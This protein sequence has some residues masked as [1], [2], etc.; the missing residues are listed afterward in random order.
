M[1]RVHLKIFLGKVLFAIYYLFIFVNFVFNVLIR[2]FG[3]DDLV[4]E[5]GDLNSKL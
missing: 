1:C 4:N 2:L 5:F 3:V